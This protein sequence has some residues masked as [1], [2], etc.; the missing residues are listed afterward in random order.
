M[1]VA[2]DASGESFELFLVSLIDSQIKPLTTLSWFTIAST[3]WLPDGSGLVTVARR[4]EIGRVFN[5]GTCPILM[6]SRAE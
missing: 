5:S 3:I 1:A 4:K 2:R 6:A